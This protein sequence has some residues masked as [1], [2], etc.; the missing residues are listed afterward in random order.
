MVKIWF[1]YGSPERYGNYVAAFRRGGAR[2]CAAETIERGKLCDALLLP[3]G[4]DIH[5]KYYGREILGAREIDE[6]RDAAE[7][8]L[9][10]D[11]LARGRPIIGICRGLQ[12]VNVFF[13][14]TLRQHI[15]GH[16][17]KNGRDTVH[18]THTEDLLLKELYGAKFFVN[19]AHHQAVDRLGTGLRAVQWAQDGTIEALRHEKLPLFA[20][21][22]HPERLHA[23][24]GAGKRAEGDELIAAICRW[25]EKV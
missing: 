18:L 15:A 4:G 5:P 17:Q 12:L 21:Q 16:E 22:W 14:G 11:F 1:L 19:S 25:A 20:L 3:G 7:F 10:E 9:V 2:V 23:A 24:G 8:A 6:A 13:G